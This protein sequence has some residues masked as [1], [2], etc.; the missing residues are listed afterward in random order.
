MFFTSPQTG[1]H[2]SFTKEESILLTKKLSLIDCM[3]F[4]EYVSFKAK[5]IEE[6]FITS[7]LLK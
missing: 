6:D 1:C 4:T 5:P 2:V 7:L 3:P